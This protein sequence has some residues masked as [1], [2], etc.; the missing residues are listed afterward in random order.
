MAE[1]GFRN[2]E[3]QS[4]ISDLKSTGKYAISDGIAHP[5]GQGLRIKNSAIHIPN[6]PLRINP[7]YIS[8]ARGDR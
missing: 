6:S 3:F 4:K 7:F 5:E 8:T 1:F 2:S